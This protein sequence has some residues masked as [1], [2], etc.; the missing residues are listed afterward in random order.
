MARLIT[1]L[2]ASTAL[3]LSVMLW[4]API[5]AA[6]T[7]KP[8]TSSKPSLNRSAILEFCPT[9]EQVRAEKRR[10]ALLK[11]PPALLD[12]TARM[13][14]AQRGAAFKAFPHQARICDALERVARGECRRLIINVPPS[15]GKTELARSFIAWCMGRWPDSEFIY[16][17]YSD[18]LATANAADIRAMMQHEEYAAIFGAPSFRRDVNAK[19]EFRTTQGGCVYA[20][21][22]GGTLTGYHAGKM[23]DGFGGAIFIDDWIKMGEAQSKIVRQGAVDWFR[24]TT[25]SRVN[26]PATPIVVIG[27]RSH[28]TDLVGWLLAGGNG[29]TWDHMCIPALD[30]QGESFCPELYP[31]ERLRRIEAGADVD[32][33]ESTGSFVFAAQYQQ[34]PKIMGGNI[35]KGEWFGRFTMPPKLKHRVIYADTASKTK[36]A[37][38]YSVFEDWGL[39]EDGRIYC[40]DLIRGKWEAPELLRRTVDFWQKRAGVNGSNGVLRCLKVEDAS[41]G[42]SLIQTI[43]AQARA[44]V[45]GIKH[46]RDKYSRLFDVLPYLESG[47]VCLPESAPWV[48]DF[49]AECEA[50]TSDDTHAHDDQ[51]DPMIDAIEDLIGAKAVRVTAPPVR[52]SDA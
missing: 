36:T 11:N 15:S 33:I 37:N 16:A 50:M 8:S 30:E 47:R 40:L 3:A 22:V 20:S 34:R 1:C 19:G 13:F 46:E 49:I 35:I 7:T 31:V 48:H 29:E 45:Q 44:P 26:S 4:P 25:E 18:A 28:S 21:G 52:R 6:P 23:R 38:D 24:G 32:G 42:T 10:R 41:S 27:Q 43:R 5:S 2:I 17:S 14:R 12:F 9:L 51:V 39:G